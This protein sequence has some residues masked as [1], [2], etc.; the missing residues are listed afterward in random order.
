MPAARYGNGDKQVIKPYKRIVIPQVTVSK[1]QAIAIKP[2]IL[3]G[4]YICP[5]CHTECIEISKAGGK[6][7]AACQQ[8]NCPLIFGIV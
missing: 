2:A 7:R 4:K 1:I 8:A 6:R 5:Q 3:A